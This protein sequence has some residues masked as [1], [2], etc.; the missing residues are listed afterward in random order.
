[1]PCRRPKDAAT[2][3]IGLLSS[4]AF[5]AAPGAAA[6]GLQRWNWQ[7]GVRPTERG[8]SQPATNAKVRRLWIA[9]QWPAPTTVLSRG[10]EPPEEWTADFARPRIG[11]AHIA[12]DAQMTCS[13]C[14]K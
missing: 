13:V 10:V 2:A 8:S 5:L 14:K 11:S 4:L 1:M 7:S 9:Q 6:G 3:L 12:A